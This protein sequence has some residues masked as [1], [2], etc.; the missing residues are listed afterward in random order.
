M[1]KDNKKY[2]RL[3][4]SQQYQDDFHSQQNINLE[5]AHHL[6]YCED[7]RMCIHQ[8]ILIGKKTALASGPLD[9]SSD[10]VGILKLLHTEIE[11][12]KSIQLPSW[13]ITDKEDARTIASLGNLDL[14]NLFHIEHNRVQYLDE[15]TIMQEAL[16]LP[17]NTVLLDHIMHDS[18]KEFVNNQYTHPSRVESFVKN[19]QFSALLL[20]CWAKKL[21]NAATSYSLRKTLLALADVGIFTRLSEKRKQLELEKAAQIPQQ[22]KEALVAVLVKDTTVGTIALPPIKKD[23][24]PILNVNREKI[25]PIAPKK[26]SEL[27]SKNQKIKRE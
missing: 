3:D 20:D 16:S 4:T 1:V 8:A 27:L 19:L 9:D 21:Y 25:S 26:E 11:N 24:T 7:L 23:L 10:I 2:S 18:V 6:T 13:A 14:Y 22:Q 17:A 15:R 12:D 5:Q